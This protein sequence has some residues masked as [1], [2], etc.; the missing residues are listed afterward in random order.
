MD[1]WALMGPILLKCLFS[2]Q[3]HK[4]SPKLETGFVGKSLRNGYCREHS[5]LCN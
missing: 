3:S 2:A 5:D 4:G 1:G